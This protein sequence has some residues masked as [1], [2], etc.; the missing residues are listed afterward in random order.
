MTD[1]TTELVLEQLRAVRNQITAF[2]SE[3]RDRLD[4]IEIRLGTMEQTI[5][6]LYSLSGADRDAMRSLTR[7][8]ER[9]E[10]RLEITD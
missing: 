4:R 7:R 10:R 1:N 2:Q 9:I 6:G 8:V 5:G 3:T